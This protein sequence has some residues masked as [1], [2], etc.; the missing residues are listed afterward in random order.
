MLDG[1]S[2]IPPQGDKPIDP[3]Q[4]QSVNQQKK[5][6]TPLQG[7]ITPLQEGGKEYLGMNFTKTQYAKFLSNMINMM[8]RQMKSD[9][10][11]MVDAIRKLGQDD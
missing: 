9:N 4:M 5:P 11:R 1:A 8:I 6:I 10:D 2:S 7:A 3:S